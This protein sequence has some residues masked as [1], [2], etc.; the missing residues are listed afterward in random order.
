M[1]RLVEPE[2]ASGAGPARA[3][4]DSDGPARW[5]SGRWDRDG[6]R[7][8]CFPH[9]GGGASAFADWMVSFAPGIAVC[10][11]Q[12]PGRENRFGEPGAADVVSLVEA[13]ADGFPA[14]EQQPFAFLGHSFGALI[15]FELAR[16]LLRRG[17]PGPLRLFLSGARAPQLPPRPAIHHLPDA[18]FLRKLGEFK[19]M[20]EEVL[21]NAE[22]MQLTLPIIRSDFRLF[23]THR[24]AVEAPVP[25]PISVFSGLNDPTTP[26]ADALAWASLTTKTFRSRFLSGDHFFLF[27]SVKEIAGFVAEDLTASTAPRMIGPAVP[28]PRAAASLAPAPAPAARPRPEPDAGKTKDS[29][30]KEPGTRQAR[31]KR[32]GSKRSGG[33]PAQGERGRTTRTERGGAKRSVRRRDTRGPHATRD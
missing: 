2:S 9:A 12:Y 22:L 27:K 15:A 32:T 24:F 7:L 29:K 25:V 30:A 3:T 11:V 33:K 4:A 1:S 26:I 13:L 23:E 16:T 31:T 14:Q 19:G 8:L 10:A 18:D 28:P 20:P 21:R 5:I 17:A 6:L